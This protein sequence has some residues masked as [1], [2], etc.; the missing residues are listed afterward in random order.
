MKKLS[1]EINRKLLADEP[2]NGMEN[3]EMM[4]FHLSDLTQ[5]DLIAQAMVLLLK[6]SGPMTP[7]KSAVQEL[8]IKSIS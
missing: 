5:S 7:E 2:L 8:L 1:D 3:I 6:D 4:K